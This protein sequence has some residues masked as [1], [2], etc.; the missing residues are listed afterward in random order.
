MTKSIAKIL[1]SEGDINALIF[2]LKVVKLYN[3]I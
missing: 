3:D 2:F 1:G